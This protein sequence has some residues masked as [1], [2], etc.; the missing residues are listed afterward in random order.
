MARATKRSGFGNNKGSL[1]PKMVV[2]A[3]EP[4]NPTLNMIWIDTTTPAV[5]V[6]NGLSWDTIAT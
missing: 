6:W 3:T 1:N 2:S 4:K 5:K